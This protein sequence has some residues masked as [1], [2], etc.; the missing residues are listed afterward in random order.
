M[1]NTEV[2]RDISFEHLRN[3]YD[4]VYIATGTQVPQKVGVPGEELSGVLPG[5]TFLKDVKLN[6]AVDLT[7]HV[8]AVIGGGNTAIDSARTALR[9]GAKRS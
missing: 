8:V 6:K 2:G 1:L 5:I 4:A 3:T 7:G 9:L